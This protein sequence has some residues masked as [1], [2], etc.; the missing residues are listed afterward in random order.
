MSCI[1]DFNARRGLD[2]YIDVVN[3]FPLLSD[4]EEFR[5]AGVW[6]TQKDET[7]RAKLVESHLRF[8]IKRARS[9]HK[10]WRAPFAELIA[11]GNIGLI[12]GLDRFDPARGFRLSTYVRWWVDA[13][14]MKYIVESFSLVKIPASGDTKKLFFHLS[15]L[16][17][18]LGITADGDMSQ[19]NVEKIAHMLKVSTENVILMNRRKQRGGD[20]SVDAPQ[21]S[22]VEEPTKRQHALVSF[23]ESPAEICENREKQILIT[24]ALK[25]LDPREQDILTQ[26]YFLDPPQTLE[27]ISERYGV[28]A[29]RIG[30]IEREALGKMRNAIEGRE[31]VP[32]K[33]KQKG[34]PVASVQPQ[35]SVSVFDFV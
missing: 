19:E 7:A 31:E 8:V 30:Q 5:L 29:Q 23:G 3:A 11:V 2:A 10:R 15:Y 21:L 18:K 20:L 9:Q 22:H 24:A 33:R 12:T 6:A 32:K 13:E 34:V 27:D 28:T 35:S 14:I 26:R 25:I 16:K 4:E 1:F 17:N